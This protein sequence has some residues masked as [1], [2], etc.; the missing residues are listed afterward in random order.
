M[1]FRYSSFLLIEQFANRVECNR[2]KQLRD[3]NDGALRGVLPRNN[4]SYHPPGASM[5][6]SNHHTPKAWSSF[7]YQQRIVSNPYKQVSRA[8]S[9]APP[10][11]QSN[12]QRGTKCD[13]QN[14]AA[15]VALPYA[16]DMMKGVTTHSRQGP[17]NREAIQ[18]PH[19]GGSVRNQRQF[20]TSMSIG[21]GGTAFAPGFTQADASS[22]NNNPGTDRDNDAASDVSSAS[23]DEDLLSFNVFGKT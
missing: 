23:S 18:H 7:G 8:Q 9:N 22:S 1:L 17:L 11:V 15:H 19:R 16:S 13:A 3:S 21:S 4:H 5:S 14:D 6:S 20:G 12:D 10:N 2:R